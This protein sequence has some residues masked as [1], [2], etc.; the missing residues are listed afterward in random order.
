MKSKDGFTHINLTQKI[1]LSFEIRK[2][3]RSFPTTRLQDLQEARHLSSASWALA[4]AKVRDL[5]LLNRPSGFGRK[6]QLAFESELTDFLSVLFISSFLWHFESKRPLVSLFFFVF[7]CSKEDHLLVSFSSNGRWESCESS[8]HREAC[9]CFFGKELLWTPSHFQLALVLRHFAVP[10]FSS[11]SAVDQSFPAVAESVTH[12]L[13]KRTVCAKTPRGMLF[14]VFL[15]HKTH[16][17]AWH[18]GGWWMFEVMHAKSQS[19]LIQLSNFG[20]QESES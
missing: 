8:S 18:L 20:A 19:A 7:V 4:T 3:V 1:S 6:K 16:Q 15:S 11:N 12:C 10:S 2:E 13:Q 14:G 9:K 17:N 5:S